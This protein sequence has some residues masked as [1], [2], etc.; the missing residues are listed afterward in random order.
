MFNILRI[1]GFLPYMAIVFLNA[2]TDLGHKIIIQN[3]IFKYYSGTE[4]IVLTAIINALILLPF[5]MLFT[6][7]G[8][9]SDKYPKNKVI[10]MA[11]AFAIVITIFIA[12]SY[13]AGWFYFAFFLTF[14]LAMQSALYSPAKY[15]YIKELVGK[16]NL[17]VGNSYVQAFTIVAILSGVFVFSLLFEHLLT[18]AFSSL[19]EILTS[20]APLGLLLIAITIL[21]TLLTFTLPNK[22]ETDTEPAFD[23][24]RYISGKYLKDNLRH[25]KGNEVIWLCI[26]GLSVFWGINQVVLASFGAYLKGTAHITNTVVAQGLLAFGGIG[27]VIGSLFA[28]K[29]S[30]RFIETGIIPI[31]AAGMTLALFFLPRVTG[32]PTQAG[33]F[34]LYGIM[35]GLFIVPL[36]ALIQFNA[37]E[38]NLGKIL[39]SNNFIQNIVMLIFLG[40]TICFA[41]TGVGAIPIFYMLFV[42]AL[43]GTLFTIIKLPQSLVR[44][45]VLGLFSQRYKLEV[46]GLKNIPSTG[47]VLILGNHVSWIDWAILQMACPR[48]IRFV[49]Q[50]DYYE[51][52]YLKKFLDLFGVVPISARA[53]KTALQ[54]VTKLLNQGEAV[55]LFPEGHLSRNGQVSIFRRGF[56]RAVKDTDA[57]IIP[58]YM[59]GLWGSIYSYASSNYRKISLSRITRTVSVCFGAA[60]SKNA[61]ALDVK[62][63]VTQLSIHSWKY[64]TDSLKPIHMEW[65]RTAKR[66]KNGKSLIDF[67]GTVFSHHRLLT[68]AI[69]FSRKIKK[70]A[71]REQNIGLLLPSSS[72][73]IIANLAVLMQGKTVVN[74]NYTA[75]KESLRHAVEQAK[76]KT[77]IT[78]KSFCK[79]L[80]AKG[81]NPAEMFEDIN[82]CF[83]ED[84]RGNISTFQMIAT[85]IAVKLL[86]A[87]CLKRM[88]FK[89]T[90]LD[91]TA[92]IL[93]SSGSEGVPK[94]IKLS[95]R[96]ILG[97]IKQ[98]S[99]VL[100]P[101]DDDVFLDTLPLFHAFGLTV[102]SLMPLV[103]GM[104][105]IC[106]PDPTN[107]YAIGK[108]A[109]KHRATLLCATS[110][111][112]R[113]YA[114]NR[115]LHPLMFQSL[116]IVVSGAEKLQKDVK[117]AFKD[118]FGLDVFEGYGTTE[119]TPVAS[120]NIPDLIIPETCFVQQ[121]AKEGTVGL[122]LPGSMFKIVD[123]E[124]LYELPVGED[125]LI[126]IGGMQVME[127]YLNDQEKTDDVIWEQDDIR[128]YK[129]GD[130]GRLDEDGFLTIVDRFSRFAK[131][132]GEM[133][134]L[135][136]VEDTVSQVVADEDVEI[137]AVT[138]PDSKKGEKIVV[139]VTGNV[140]IQGM[141]QKMKQKKMSPL[142]MPSEFIKADAIPK[143]GSGK[144]D[145]SQAKKMAMEMV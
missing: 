89:N 74:L 101:R 41:L 134:S 96:N 124:T 90:S 94:G 36:N 78:S 130:K 17:A 11:S 13:Y 126:L 60:L 4:Q 64:Y 114:K 107:A 3:A 123:P 49:M 50:R 32:I 38:R 39:A 116:R 105:F 129:T 83:M 110:T 136:A 65:L 92:A 12:V 138:L 106:H 1:K 8:F 102:T 31:G 2:F 69:A 61:S 15:G 98:V 127:G 117:D 67:N 47:G 42:T 80:E 30:R 85:L 112:L 144:N 68:A 132:G 40:L 25:A 73:G 128:W 44:Y 118:K 82:V 119:T 28:G 10:K 121:G 19:S 104:T 56:E 14:L 77:I 62:I 72:G 9:L 24:K 145:F 122:P 46:Y 35:G 87:F 99:S 48:R 100:N 29:V 5:V 58:F 57:V 84:I 139:L 86:P 51:K 33:L 16:E 131:I 26:I 91:A 133:I 37:E 81:S 137:A 70:T 23:R 88:F 125:G 143:L 79:K 135:G 53:S 95:H 34:C 18:P 59:K 111:F 97:N 43:I 75:S 20:I 109:T 22:K 93:F 142:M 108:L 71:G 120:V 66:K 103:E 63:A 140:D 115:K 55:A 6:P 113:I 52:W 21:E 76:I 54:T 27:I 141:K 45:L 7:A